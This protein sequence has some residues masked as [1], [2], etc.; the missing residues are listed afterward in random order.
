MPSS[1]WGFEYG[2]TV[3]AR[4]PATSW[5]MGKVAGFTTRREIIVSTDKESFI[6]SDP[7]MI[8]PWEHPSTPDAIEEFLNR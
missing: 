1:L 2:D 7:R 6:V 8:R 3:E 4:Q 5:S